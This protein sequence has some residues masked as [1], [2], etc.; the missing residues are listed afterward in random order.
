MQKEGS[1]VLD[2]ANDSALHRGIDFNQVSNVILFDGVEAASAISFSRYS[3]RIG[4]TG[5]AGNEGLAILLLSVPQAHTVLRPLRLHLKEKHER[6]EALTKLDR[7]QAAKL[8]YRVDTVLAN[9]TRTATR[10]LRV[11][12]VASELARSSYLSTH[13]S[14]KDTSILKKIVNKSQ[15]S[16]RS[17]QDMLDLPHY[18]KLGKQ[19]DDVKAYKKRVNAY[20]DTRRQ[21][22]FAAVV[23]PKANDP[24]RNAMKNAKDAAKNEALAK[25]KEDRLLQKKARK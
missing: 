10:R 18:M 23:K 7:A 25:L 16:V 14:S 15:K 12:T 22:A 13:L 8:Q 3:H 20:A 1:S 19:V 6:I 9:V 11:A 21:N 24:L 5:R 2:K 17:D 4:R